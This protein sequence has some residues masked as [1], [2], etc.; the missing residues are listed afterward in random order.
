MDGEVL[1]VETHIGSG[2]HSGEADFQGRDEGVDGGL[3]VVVVVV[4]LDGFDFLQDG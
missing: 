4:V 3:H 1:A 2:E